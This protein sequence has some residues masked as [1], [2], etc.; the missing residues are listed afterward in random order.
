MQTRFLA[1]RIVGGMAI[2]AGCQPQPTASSGQLPAAARDSVVAAV[3]AASDRM[4]NSMRERNADSV[5]A[6]YGKATAYAGNGAVGD[7]DAIVKGTRP[8]YATYAKVDCRWGDPQRI[9]V[10]SRTS[11]VLTAAMRCEKA[12]TSGRVWREDGARTEVLTL[13]A[14]RWQI[15]A[16]HESTKPGDELR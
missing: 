1:L 14:G 12:D 9:D 8:R 11:A 5:L 13:V 16:V 10:L 6:F 2:L 7:W 15:V 4:F 3:R